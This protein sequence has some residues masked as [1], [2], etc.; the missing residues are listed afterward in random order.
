MKGLFLVSCVALIMLG[1]GNNEAPS[2]N[3]FDLTL[4]SPDQSIEVTV[5]LDERG[6][7]QYRVSHLGRA[8]LLASD[9]GMALN[10]RDFTRRLRL[11]QVSEP[12]EVE[13]QYTLV[14]G[15]QRQIHYKAREK[16]YSFANAGSQT[17]EII[18]RVSNDG[19]AFRYRFPGESSQPMTVVEESTSFRFPEQT[20]GWL[21]PMQEA[22]SG[23]NRTNP[24][25]EEHYQL[26]IAAGTPAP[27]D[28]G[29]VFPALFHTGDAW[30]LITEAGMD[31]RFHASRLGSD[32][33]GGEYH[34]DFP[35]PEE[36][37]LDGALKAQAPL[38]L[39]SPW[40]IIAL[41][42][43]A[44]LAEST[45]GTDL[46]E[47]ATDMDEAFIK[48][49]LASWSWALLKDE[50]VVYEVQREY[51]DYAAEMNW[52]YTLVDVDWDRRIGYAKLEELADY[53]AERGI[54]LL[55]WYNS[56]GPWN[57][58]EYTP[59][60]KLLTR[61]DRRT[62]FARLREMGVRGIKVDFFPGDGQ[63]AIQY[64]I[65]IL[66]DAADFK[67]LVNVHGSTL[68]RG[69]HRTYPHFMTSEA[70]HGFEMI[71]FTQESADLEASHATT[72]IY[73]RNAF[74]P[75]DFT[76]TVFHEIPNIE[77]KT[78]NGFQLALPVLFL[79]GIQHIAETPEGMAGVPDYVKSFM[80]KLPASWDE[81]RFVQGYPG[82]LA[83]FARRSGET[84]YLAGI[85]GEHRAKTVALDLSF[86][87]GSSA[88][89]ITDGEQPRQFVRQDLA[90][91]SHKIDLKPAG[92]FVVVVK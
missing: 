69:L 17:L 87:G 76:P 81:S 72:L 53:A 85:N 14:Q 71:S 6:A 70:V 2:E 68:P 9:L 24:A 11:T 32:S 75:M 77:R 27:T 59:K 40:R 35:A 56:S 10:D 80:R 5:S 89:L 12:R 28:A 4:T 16:T 67:L 74:D 82:K 45:L 88:T 51:I 20:R 78:T 54:G 91:G 43:L 73:A 86:T 60:S 57:D 52:S 64:Y 92:G 8:V 61:E 90:I 21:Q 83:V 7:A 79:S 23:W 15:K 84:W 44:T 18:F 38:P 1:C 3:P 29:W 19:V 36:T 49:G 26:G 47:P 13:D 31:G 42:D 34:I 30:A 66:H 48:P 39:S 50:S 25:Y 65:D 63:S 41:G 62:E 22:K 46:A 37:F 33:T 55:V 58:T